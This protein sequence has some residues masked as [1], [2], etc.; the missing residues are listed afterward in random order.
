[1]KESATHVLATLH[2]FEH[3]TW[4]ITE[5]KITPQDPLEPTLTR[6]NVEQELGNKATIEYCDS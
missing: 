1:M 3:P 4:E 5:M 2:T 6:K